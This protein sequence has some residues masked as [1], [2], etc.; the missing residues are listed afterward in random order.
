MQKRKTLKNRIVWCQCVAFIRSLVK[1][2]PAVVEAFATD[3]QGA[4]VC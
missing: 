2:N 4:I 3:N 1:Q